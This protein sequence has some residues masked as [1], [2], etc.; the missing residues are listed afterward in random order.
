[1][2][3]TAGMRCSGACD[4]VDCQILG[5]VAD[6]PSIGHLLVGEIHLGFAGSFE[7]AHPNVANDANDLA[8]VKTKVEMP[9]DRLLVRP[10]SPHKGFTDHRDIRA[11]GGVGFADVA[12]LT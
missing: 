12:A 8:I 1:M 3:R 11:I 6:D 5:C 4:G 7:A 10:V 2:R 9:S